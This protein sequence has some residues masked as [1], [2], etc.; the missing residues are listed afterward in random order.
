MDT[1]V[2]HT[3]SAAAVRSVTVMVTLTCVTQGVV[4]HTRG[5]VSRVSIIQ[6]G[7]IVRGVRTGTMVMPSKPKTANVSEN[8]CR[9]RQPLPHSKELELLELGFVVTSI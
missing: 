9:S 3:R 6:P 5:P 4:I 8:F 7:S 2:T 1:G